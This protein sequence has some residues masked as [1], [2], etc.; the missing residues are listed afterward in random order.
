MEPSSNLK[1]LGPLALLAGIW[2]GEK[3]DDV[4]PDE[5]R[6]IETNRF[7]ERLILDPTGQVDNHE[8]VLYGLKY[9]TV[10][11]RIGEEAAFHQEVGYWLWDAQNKQV[12]RCFIVPRGIAVIA[13]G[14]VDPN[15]REF[16]L[17]ADL[18]SATYGICSNQFLDR[19][20]KTV[21]YELKIQIHSETSFTYEEDTQ[22]QMKGRSELFHHTDKNTLQR[23]SIL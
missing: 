13:G 12:M 20:F 14:T 8:Q 11:W 6:K 7:R 10:A 5:S 9:S 21:R 3:G 22:M 23:V 4:S 1:N 19:E 16:S 18:G 17:S 2:E 15:A